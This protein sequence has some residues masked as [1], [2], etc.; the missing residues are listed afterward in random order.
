MKKLQSHPVSYADAV[1]FSIMKT[2]GCTRAFSYDWHFCIAGFA[3]LLKT[4]EL[5][6]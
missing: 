3:D 5:C 6:L 1:S 2:A 4:D